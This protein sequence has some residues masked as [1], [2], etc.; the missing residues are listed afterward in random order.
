MDVKRVVILGF[1]GFGREVLE[2]LLTPPERQREGIEVLGCVSPEKPSGMRSQFTSWWLGSDD[3]VIGT[4]G[5][6]HF[7]VG[8]SDPLLKLRL[9][10]RYTA[11]GI[12]SMSVR[13]PTSLIGSSVEVGRGLV[14]CA[15]SQV[16]TDVQVGDHVHIDRQAMLGH[17]CVVGEYA[18]LH[19]AAVV[20]GGVTIGAFSVLGTGCRVLPGVQIGS[21][22]TVG[23]GA[24]VTRDVP[25]D[26]TVAGVPAREWKP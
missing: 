3:D 14:L 23:A 24:V 20:S 4:I 2:L 26:V 22:C 12:N 15:G 8:V 21:H 7:V 19:P 18:T 1:G 25:D 13:H 9:V 5:A 11:A 17:D 10:E 16:T 6:T